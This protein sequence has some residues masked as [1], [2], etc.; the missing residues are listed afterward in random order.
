MRLCS[1]S[2][3]A[4]EYLNLAGDFLGTGPLDFFRSQPR[5]LKE[6]Q[7]CDAVQRVRDLLEGSWCL[8]SGSEGWSV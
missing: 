4:K 3:A 5:C 2:R 7:L 6:M 8:L 1:E